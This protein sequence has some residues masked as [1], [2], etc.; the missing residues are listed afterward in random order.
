MADRNTAH[1]D[2]ELVGFA[3][4][5]STLLDA[6]KMIALDATGYAVH[7]SDAAGLK[8]VG[9][10]DE[11]V[12]NSSGAAGAATVMVRRKKAFLFKNDATNAVAQAHVGGNV[13]VKDAVTVDSDGGTNNIVA[14]KCI[15]IETGGVWVE[16][17]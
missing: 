3:V 12:D 14:G 6:G 4:K 1:K 16:I 11:A 5:A 15:G 13:Y 10:S 17:N 7:A 8:V 2:G 9:M